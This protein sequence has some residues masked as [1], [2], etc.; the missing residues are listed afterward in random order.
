MNDAQCSVFFWDCATRAIFC[1]KIEKFDSFSRDFSVA[2]R[3][4]TVLSEMN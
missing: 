3:G 1:R 4:G 2:D